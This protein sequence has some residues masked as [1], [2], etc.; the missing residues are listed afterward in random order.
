MLAD[1]ICLAV[2][3][4]SLN[5]LVCH[6]VRGRGR[7]VA[8]AGAV[9][10]TVGGICFAMGGFAFATITWF[11]SGISEDAGRELV[12]YANDN[13]PHL[14]GASMSGFFLFT[15]GGLVLA[16]ALMLAR[17]VPAAG[18]AAYALLVVA[19]FTPLPGRAL[20]FLQIAMMA[21]FVTLAV[22]VLRRSVA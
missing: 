9:L 2:V 8:L 17:A 4:V 11:A 13:V 12:G 22:S 10:T 5:I 7:A 20:D 21:L 19:Q 1:G 6:L 18:V 16:G 15:V 3:A 14:L